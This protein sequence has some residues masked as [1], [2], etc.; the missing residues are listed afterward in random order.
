MN[1]PAPVMLEQADGPKDPAR[2]RSALQAWLAVTAIVLTSLLVTI[3]AMRHTSP[4][5][6]EIT[7]GPGGARGFHTGTFDM[8]PD[9]PPVMQ[10]LYGL[11]VYLSRPNYPAEVRTDTVPH[12][13]VYAQQFMYDNGN[14]PER[15]TFRTRLVASACAA[16]LILL[17]F[18]FARAYFGTGAALLAASLVAFLPDV[19]AHGGIAYNDIAIAPAFLAALWAV[20]AGLRRPAAWRGILAGALVSLAVGIK[21]SALILGPVAIA[22]ILLETASRIQRR[23]LRVWAPR[24]AIVLI[25]A[26]LTGYLFQ[27]LLYRGDFSLSYLRASTMAAQAHIESGHGVAAYLLGTMTREAPWYYYPVTFLYKTS[28]ALHLLMLIALVGAIAA[29]PSMKWREVAASSLR[30]PVIALLLFGAVLLRANLVIGFR[31]AL[32]LL[33]IICVLVAAGAMYVWRTASTIVRAMIVL[34]PA[35]A[36]ASSLAYYPHFVAYT[37]EYNTEPELGY[38]VFVDSSLDWGQG[39]L[40]LRDWMREE[41]VESVYLSYFGSAVPAGYGIRYEPLISFFPLRPPPEPSAEKPRYVAISATNLVGLYFT[42][43]VFAQFRRIQPYRVLGHSMFIYEV[44]E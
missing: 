33:P 35:A 25:A 4:T 37:S 38:T 1:A 20:D 28:V 6:D 22:L 13:Y 15:I 12:R 36:A 40:A 39:L 41:N 10:Y 3:A 7:T 21:H 26:A 9:F 30:A 16:L 31:Y 32:P 17:T 43:D 14:D 2:N 44:P 8:M 11:P 18:L 23:E 34:L 42:Q 5:F 24:F 27:V 19:L 29:A